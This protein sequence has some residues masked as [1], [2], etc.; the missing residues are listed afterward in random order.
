MRLN[1]VA[2]SPSGRRG[3]QGEEGCYFNKHLL[4]AW[5]MMV[6]WKIMCMCRPRRRLILILHDVF[7]MLM[8]DIIYR[9][10]YL[11]LLNLLE[12][13]TYIF[14]KYARYL[15][16]IL[17]QYL[18]STKGAYMHLSFPVVLSRATTRYI[19]CMDSWFLTL[20]FFHIILFVAF[21]SL[22][23]YSRITILL[24]LINPYFSPA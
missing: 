15:R 13:Q 24:N 6:K 18:I 14:E 3:R 8:K 17:Q 21:K 2:V 10:K 12:A 9:Y 7:L 23:W 20:H 4:Y 5:F 22:I 1:I 19:V 11:Y 16:N